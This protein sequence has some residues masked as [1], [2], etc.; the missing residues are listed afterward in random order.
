MKNAI[1]R[2]HSALKKLKQTKNRLY[3]MRNEIY[4]ALN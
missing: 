4:A 3:C 1:L 2:N